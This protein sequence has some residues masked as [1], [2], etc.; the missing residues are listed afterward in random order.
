M[1]AEFSAE[2]PAMEAQGK[3]NHSR[4]RC[5][6]LFPAINRSQ[7]I[8]VALGKPRN[9]CD[10]VSRMNLGAI[11]AE[12]FDDISSVTE[13]IHNVAEVPSM[14]ESQRVA[15]FVHARQVD[16]AVAQQ[17]VSPGTSRE[18]QTQRIYVRTNEDCRSWLPA[19]NDRQRFPVLAAVRAGPI[20]SNQ[21]G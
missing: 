15:E 8:H 3:Q 9:R 7:A 16:N 6:D 12:V 17:G 21:C 2:L 18:G 11:P 5:C 19:D 10:I 14:R 13:V 20:E 1:G 4:S